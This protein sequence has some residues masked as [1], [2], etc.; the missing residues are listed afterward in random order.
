MMEDNTTVQEN[1][2]AT[3]LQEQVSAETENESPKQQENFSRE[4]LVKQLKELL[5]QPTDE[6][7]EKVELL[8]MKFYR[9]SAQQQQDSIAPAT[10][11]TAETV[12]DISAPVIDEVEKTFRQL[13]TVYKQKKAEMAAKREAELQQNKLRKENIIAQMRTLSESETA[14]VSG[15]I[16]KVRELQQEWKSI[17]A[18]PPQDATALS[19]EYN[20]YQERF[21][22]LVK[23]NNELREYDFKKNLE[24]KTTLCVQAEALIQQTNI[25]EAFRQLQSLHEQWVNIGP[26]ARDEREALWTRFKEA[27]TVINKRHQAYFEQLH[28][29]EEENLQKK[30]AILDKLHSFDFSQFT[31]GKMWE[32]ANKQILALQDEWRSIGFAPKKTNQKIYD[33]YRELC[34]TFFAAKTAFYKNIRNTLNENLKKKQELLNKAEEW[35][36]SKDWKTATTMFVQLQKEWKNVGPVARKYSEDVWKRFSDACDYFFEQKKAEEKGIYTEEQENLQKKQDILKEIEALAVN[37]TEDAATKLKEL[38]SQYGSI[39]HVPFKEKD[40]LYKRFRSACDK[41]FDQLHI[42]EQSRRIDDFCKDMEE[43]DS[44]TLLNDR[45]RLVRQYEALKQE[46]Q[47]AENNILFFT[48]QSKKS[49]NLLADMQKKID[50]LHKQLTDIEKKINL[51]DSRLQ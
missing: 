42:D 25:V 18:V 17:G 24:A 11:N 51:I 16:K 15:S 1:P 49:N 31:T 28:Q 37:A 33:E 19:K 39:G 23:I 48:A 27:S 47:T 32:D 21:Y 36:D 12:E 4:E 46:I 35:K 2:S 30:Q 3:S 10:E 14:D 41:V 8:K 45:R 38:M 43:K 50:N 22:D 34:N 44:N 9:Q 29:K 13:L 6:I 5:E 7:R 26:V 20:L 40:K